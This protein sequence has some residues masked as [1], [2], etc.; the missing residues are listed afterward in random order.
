MGRATVEDMLEHATEDQ[1]L[2]WHLTTNHFPPIHVCFV[3]VAKQAIARG[4]VATEAPAVWDEAI[5]MRNKR[6]MTVREIVGALHLWPFI[7]A[8][9]EGTGN[10]FQLEEARP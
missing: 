6:T 5:T 1:A 3:P 9:I 2:E 4:V 8:R 7:E 10:G